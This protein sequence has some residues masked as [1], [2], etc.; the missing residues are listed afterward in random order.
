MMPA[1]FFAAT[2][3][4]TLVAAPTHAAD[5]R[6]LGQN[7]TNAAPKSSSVRYIDLGSIELDG[8]LVRFSTLLVDVPLAGT[9]SITRH[10]ADC[11]SA[12]ERY[13]SIQS[14]AGDELEYTIQPSGKHALTEKSGGA[15]AIAV[16]CGKTPAPTES[17]AD[18]YADM[19]ARLRTDR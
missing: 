6:Y 8:S 15:R 10:E 13:L 18:P 7:V 19:L 2:L 9:Y 14:W 16:A 3:L 5:W 17:A 4:S 1:N 11:R 12:K